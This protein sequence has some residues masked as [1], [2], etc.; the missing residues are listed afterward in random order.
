MKTGVKQSCRRWHGEPPWLVQFTG[1]YT[2]LFLSSVIQ[3]NL[4]KHSSSEILINEPKPNSPLW[5]WP[6]YKAS[7]GAGVSDYVISI[8]L[9]VSISAMR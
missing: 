2:K 1:L 3:P 8:Q 6:V 9:L 7:E 4:L 5:G